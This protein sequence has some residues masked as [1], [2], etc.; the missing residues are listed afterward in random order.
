MPAKLSR[1][2][3]LVFAFSLGVAVCP[4]PVMAQDGA[5]T[6]KVS[7]AAA[8]SE[9]LIAD[10]SFIGR[11]QAIDKVDIMARVN[12]YLQDVLVEDGAVVEQGAP[13]FRIEPDAYEATLQ[14]RVA[15]HDRAKA[16]LE[17]A[18]I[19]LTRKE[20]LV[21]R[22]AAAQSE[23]DIARANQLIATAGVKAA[24][25]AIR[26]AELD[27]S[28]TEIIA[29]FPGRIGAVARSIGD[30]VGPTTPALV[31]L[32]REQPMQVSF[33]VTEK[34]LVNL[35]E[36]IEAEVHELPSSKKTPDV[37][38]TLPNGTKLEEP[39]RVVFIDN[40]ID[41]TTGTVEMRAEFSNARRLILD[42]AF[43]DV[44]IQ[45]L[46]PETKLL[47][48]QAAVQRDQRGDFVLV[49]KPDQLVEQRY[50]TLGR[51]HETASVVTDGM[52]E[53]EMVIVEGLQRVRPGVKV[54]SV[55]SGQPK[56]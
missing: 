45:A 8:Y 1:L 26:A 16:N 40:R 4:L 14:A 12:G 15:D 35:A 17:L 55:L 51:Q 47:I 34:E 21:N 38:V 32:V 30:T 24:E 56:E 18:G 53:G 19:E 2:S 27:L 43:V 41:P 11:G 54:E 52:M 23:A 7:V 3:P 22:E 10:V 31:T 49:V 28:Y 39:G 13:L 44:T 29:P 9:D 50:V 20:E 6:V 37:F 46:E 33:S 48:P 25:A 5:A 42:G 36:S